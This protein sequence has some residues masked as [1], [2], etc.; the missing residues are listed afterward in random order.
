MYNQV[1]IASVVPACCSIR[2]SVVCNLWCH[3]YSPLLSLHYKMANVLLHSLKLIISLYCEWYHE[4]F[5]LC[6]LLTASAYLRSYRLNLHQL[7]CWKNSKD[8]AKITLS[9]INSII[10]RFKFCNVKLVD[11]ILSLTVWQHF[12]T[13]SR[14]VKLL[15]LI[16]GNSIHKEWAGGPEGSLR[17]VSVISCRT[18]LNTLQSQFI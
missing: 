10:F 9:Q 6:L 16:E 15:W 18:V 8:L 12:I 1:A 17:C 7:R 2:T 11:L 4:F 3:I 14:L 5:F 13:K